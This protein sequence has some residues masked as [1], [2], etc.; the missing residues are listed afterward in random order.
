MMETIRRI[1][2][3]STSV[4]VQLFFADATSV[5]SRGFAGLTY[6]ESGLTCYYK[7]DTAT[8]AVQVTLATVATLGTWETGGLKLISDANMPGWVEFHIPNAAL[9][10]GANEVVFAFKGVTDMVDLNLKIELKVDVNVAQISGDATAADN[11]ESYTDGTTPQPVNVTQ[12]SGD[13]TAADNAE[14]FFDGTGYAGT[15]NVIPTVTTVNGLAANS[16]NAS[17]VAADAVTEIQSGLATAAALATVAGYID[18]EMATVLANVATIL[19]AVDTEVAAIKAKTDNLPAAPAAV[20]DIPTVANIWTTVLTESYPA[21]AASPTGAQLLFEIG[22]FLMRKSTG[23]TATLTTKRLDG[24][25]T[26]ETF[27]LNDADDPT[28]IARAS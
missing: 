22:A 2:P 24:T 28:S 23:G 9:A 27:T 7:R 3:G 25:T 18:T 4:I 11:L 20:G 6:D 26:A 19:A 1:L 5:L 13:A 21:L 16:V 14:S 8:A 12:V 17:A 15:N 10:V